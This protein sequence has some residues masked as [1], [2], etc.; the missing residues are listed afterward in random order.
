MMAQTYSMKTA[1][2]VFI[3]TPMRL[4]ITRPKVEDLECDLHARISIASSG[5]S[6]YGNLFLRIL[7]IFCLIAVMGCLSASAQVDTAF[8]QG[9]IL[10]FLEPSHSAY[11]S[12][13]TLTIVK[14]PGYVTANPAIAN[15][16]GMEG[17]RGTWSV[18]IPDTLEGGAKI[19]TKLQEVQRGDIQPLPAD[20]SGSGKTIDLVDSAYIMDIDTTRIGLTGPAQ[21][22]MSV[23]R[24]WVHDNG[25][26]EATRIFRFGNDGTRELLNTRFS[27][28]DRDTGYINLKADSPHGLG[29]F[30]LVAVR[31]RASSQLD[32]LVPE[33]VLDI[34]PGTINSETHG[35][36]FSPETLFT[37]QA[38]VLYLLLVLLFIGVTRTKK[39]FL[40]KFYNLPVFGLVIRLIHSSHIKR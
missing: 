1:V 8:E 40:H 32:I 6:D 10:D 11:P 31:Q 36:G 37:I 29:M 16:P 23:S 33:P 19:R 3:R 28:Y 13:T 14:D 34:Q 5:R 30:V 24:E 35:S 20:S 17:I 15:I 38:A 9:E 21:V 22:E 18:E 4:F 25:G 27:N 2:A 7:G 39:S 26:L 12:D